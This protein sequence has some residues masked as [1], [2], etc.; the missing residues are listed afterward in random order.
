ML[1]KTLKPFK[2]NLSNY[3]IFKPKY[4]YFNQQPSNFD[5]KKDYYTSLNVSKEASES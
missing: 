3:M 5:A 2:K 1:K 4:C